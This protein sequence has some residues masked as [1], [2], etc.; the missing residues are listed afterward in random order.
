MKDVSKC[1]FENGIVPYMYGELPTREATEFESHL[2]ECSACTD[3][4]AAVSAARYEVYE[5]KKLEFE[6]LATPVIELPEMEP[7][8]GV[9]WIDK[10][11]AVFANSW[12]IPTFAFAGLAIATAF[13]LLFVLT[14]DKEKQIVARN[15]NEPVPASTVAEIKA[16]KIATPAKAPSELEKDVVAEPRM[17]NSTATKQTPSRR[18]RRVERVVPPKVDPLPTTAQQPTKA[19]RLNGFDEEED[20]SLRL[21]ELFENIDTRE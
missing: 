20:T 21:A 11:R 1:E 5:W 7:A 14:G 18:T 16:A 10:L 19:P 2:L 4:F 9:S 8:G 13:T 3:E 15:T 17:V 6:P 12:A